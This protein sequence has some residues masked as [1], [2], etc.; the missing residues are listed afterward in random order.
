MRGPGAV[1]GLFALESAMDELAIKLNMDPLELRLK[2]DAER[3]EGKNLPFSSR[4]L[5]E[6]YTTGAEKIGWKQRTAEVGSMRRNGKI[7]GMGLAGAS[8]SAARIPC[9]ASVELCPNG[10]VCVRCA[11]QDIGT[12]TYTIFAQ[13]I[14]ARTGVP[15]DR[16]DVFLGDTS[17]A[18]RTDIRRVDG[19]QRGAAGSHQRGLRGGN[20]ASPHRHDHTPIAL[21]W[22]EA[23]RHWPSQTES[24]IRRSNRRWLVSPCVRAAI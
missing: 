17:S 4:H 22:H 18:R 13:V 11:T 2:N 7:I 3:D 14:H 12:G 23:V 16:I 21:P 24:C 20:A 5:K 15:L 8:W 19:H 6:C 9:T 10:R 1:P